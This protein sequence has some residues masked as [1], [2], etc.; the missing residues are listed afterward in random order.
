MT[1][2]LNMTVDLDRLILKGRETIRVLVK[3]NT[4][5]VVIHSAVNVRVT[6]AFL[7]AVP[8]LTPRPGAGKSFERAFLEGE[9]NHN[10]VLV[11]C[12]FKFERTK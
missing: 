3:T 11:S 12:L 1:Y 10:K 9:D 2:V 7:T 6:Q 5:F 4:T 8:V